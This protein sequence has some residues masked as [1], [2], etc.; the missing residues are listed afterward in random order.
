MFNGI[1]VDAVFEVFLLK[2]TFKD[3]FKKTRGFFVFQKAVVNYPKLIQKYLGLFF[4]ILIIIL[5]R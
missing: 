3:K 1:A 4:P 5:L 2:P